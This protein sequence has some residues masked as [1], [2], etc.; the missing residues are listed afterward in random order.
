MGLRLITAP[1]TTPISL[2]Q[3]K[4]HLRVVDNDEDDLITALII[5]A[6]DYVETLLG[7][8]L[9]DQTWELVLDAFPASDPFATDTIPDIAD[10]AIKIPKPPLIE[11]ISINYAD[12]SGNDQVVASSSY[13]V[14]TTSRY[15]WV[16]P[17]GGALAWPATINAINSVRIRFRAGF[18][19]SGSSPP[20]ENIPKSITAAMFLLIGALYENREQTVVATIANKLPWGVDELLLRYRV[21]MSMA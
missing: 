7:R 1:A 11:V 8:A 5:A 15:G 12:E 19:D 4:A 14:D 2:D 3:A 9:I 17:Q 10:G 18:L 16:V 21:D 13:Y 6:T 20:V